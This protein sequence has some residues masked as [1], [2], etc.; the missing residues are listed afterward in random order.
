MRDEVVDGD[1]KP[2]MVDV[3]VTCDLPEARS[4]T[5]K[6]SGKSNR[7]KVQNLVVNRGGTTKNRQSESNQSLDHASFT[8]LHPKLS[9]R[10]ESNYNVSNNHLTTLNEK[11]PVN[12]NDEFSDIEESV[13]QKSLF[14]VSK[15]KR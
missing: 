12:L 6:R 9:H 8:K 4:T 5:P 2:Q 11:E 15:G 14:K 10:D 3:A 1:M 7:K 13:N